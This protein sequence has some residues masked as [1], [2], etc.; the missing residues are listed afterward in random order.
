M[1]KGKVEAKLEN[2]AEFRKEKSL[3][4]ASAIM[5][6][7]SRD[8]EGVFFVYLIPML[9]KHGIQ[10]SE[11]GA[12]QLQSAR[13]CK[14]VKTPFEK[15]QSDAEKFFKRNKWHIVW[16]FGLLAIHFTLFIAAFF[17]FRVAGN[18]E[19]I[20]VVAEEECS[21]LIVR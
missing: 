12:L 18:N 11:H 9:L 5:K 13:L 1:N 8:H 21:I 6:D 7:A 16:M 10:V 20:Q 3:G 14:T 2:N 15:F 17:E 19:W 4:V